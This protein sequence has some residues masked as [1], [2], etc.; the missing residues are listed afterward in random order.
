MQ[1][2]VSCHLNFKHP[3]S[4][5]IKKSIRNTN[6]IHKSA[7][8]SSVTQQNIGNLRDSV[9]PLFAVV[10]T[11]I[12]MHIY[13]SKLCQAFFLVWNDSNVALQVIF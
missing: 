4:T 7:I 8:A 3:Y 6:K 5:F 12:I 13:N 11:L 1:A 9:T 10:S 2:N